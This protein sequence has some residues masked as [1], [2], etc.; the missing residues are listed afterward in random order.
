MPVQWAVDHETQTV[1]VTATDVVILKDVQ[2]Y[3]DG[4]AH[5]ATLSYRKLLDLTDCLL[6]LTENDL[7]ELS[8]KTEA[9]SKSI[10]MGPAAIVTT[11]KEVCGKAQTFETLT[12]SQRRLRIFKA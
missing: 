8:A 5:V 3:L 6:A 10:M 12:A 4:L 11:S 9:Y 1:M 2:Q 7:F